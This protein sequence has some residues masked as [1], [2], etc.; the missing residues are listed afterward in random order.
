MLLIAYVVVL[1]TTLCALFAHI[2]DSLVIGVLAAVSFIA[3]DTFGIPIAT[4]G[5]S[6]SAGGPPN[7][8]RQIKSAGRRFH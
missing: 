6:F 1:A 4:G 8:R 5:A 3:F 7:G 2:A